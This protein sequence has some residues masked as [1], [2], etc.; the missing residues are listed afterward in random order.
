MLVR[1][2]GSS[3]SGRAEPLFSEIVFITQQSITPPLSLSERRMEVFLELTNKVV[4]TECLV[5][6]TVVSERQPLLITLPKQ[7]VIVNVR[8]NS[9]YQYAVTFLTLS[10]HLLVFHL[11]KSTSFAEICSHD[12]P[13]T[14]TGEIVDSLYVAEAK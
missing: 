10:F 9:E 4:K 8:I 11:M 7:I 1:N 2:S 3:C 12:L 5:G 13:K 14:E 6:C